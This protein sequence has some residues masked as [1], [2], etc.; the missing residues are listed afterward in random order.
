MSTQKVFQTP[1]HVLTIFD[2]TPR[3]MAIVKRQQ[4]TIEKNQMPKS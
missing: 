2:D 4:M 3:E 1:T